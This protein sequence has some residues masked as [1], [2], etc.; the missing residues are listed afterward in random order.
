MPIGAYN[1]WRRNHCNSEETLQMADKIKA[2]HFIPIHTKT[3]KLG[4][5]PF[6]EAVNRPLKSAPD[7][8][9]KIGLH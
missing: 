7:Y 1:P 2:R 6:D 3:F 9:T 4:V 5:E 8:G